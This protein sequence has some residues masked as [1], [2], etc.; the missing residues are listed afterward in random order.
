MHAYRLF[1]SLWV[2]ISLLGMTASGPSMANA[3]SAATVNCAAGDSIQN[4][5]DLAEGNVVVT[6]N[7]FCQEA[8]V[9]SHDNVTLQ[10]GTGM[11]VDGIDGDG[12]IGVQIIGATNAE[13]LQL[14][15]QGRT[16]VQAQRN[17]AVEIEGSQIMASRTGVNGLDGA[18][19][20]INNSDV[21]APR[22]AI[23]LIDGANAV[24][25]GND[26]TNDDSGR[27]AIT[28]FRK[29]NL[30]MRGGN[31]VRNLSGA[32]AIDALASIVFQGGSGDTIIGDV[33]VINMSFVG[34]N[35]VEVTGSALIIHDSMLLLEDSSNDPT[36]VTWTGPLSVGGRLVLEGPITID[37]DIICN[38]FTNAFV[39]SPVG[40][41]ESRVEGVTLL[42]GHRFID[43]RDSAP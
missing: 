24:L 18:F 10:G 40:G 22:R 11:G 6:I 8:V 20:R 19:L 7:G 31:T 17:A 42:N 29:I 30:R 3:A 4:A 15:I 16:G 12:G 34:F 5:L 27:A 23:Q 41:V 21:Q 35:N 33:R 9:V 28:L 26:I 1:G 36:H 37:G 13:I 38:K 14:T 39:S 25:E 43:C 2:T 32:S